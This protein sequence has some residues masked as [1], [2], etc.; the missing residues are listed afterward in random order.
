MENGKRQIKSITIIATLLLVIILGSTLAIYADGGSGT[1]PSTD[2]N[3]KIEQQNKE[4]IDAINKQG[5]P[6]NAE[7]MDQ[8]LEIVKKNNRNATGEFSVQGFKLKLLSGIFT[9]AMTIRK[10]AVYFYMLIVVINIILLGVFGSH[11]LQKRK[12]YIVGS[13]IFTVLFIFLMNYPMFYIYYSSYPLSESITIETTANV[14]DTFLGFLRSNSIALS[15]ILY[16]YG[17]INMQLG[18]NDIPRVIAGEY[19]KKVAVWMFIILQALP[20]AMNFII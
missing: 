3:D 2:I 4:I 17:I 15:T 16:I 1:K 11:S 19:Y 18:K 20:I 7:M 13:I 12:T 6:D 5:V 9:I 8:M 14:V 10:Y